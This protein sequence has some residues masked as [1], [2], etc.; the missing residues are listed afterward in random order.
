MKEFT[1][2]WIE[3]KSTTIKTNNI[4]QYKENWENGQVSIN[5]ATVKHEG[6]YLIAC[7]ENKS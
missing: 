2:I 3:I 6:E 1:I 5:N 4:K 7:N